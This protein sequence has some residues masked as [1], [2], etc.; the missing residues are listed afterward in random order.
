MKEIKSKEKQAL[1]NGQIILNV[2][3]MTS[4]RL[5]KRYFVIQ[6]MTVASEHLHFYQ[7]KKE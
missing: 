5:K 7:K 4:Q 2:C 3:V 1:K 6:Q